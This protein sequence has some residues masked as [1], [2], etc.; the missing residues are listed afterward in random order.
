M[1]KERDLISISGPLETVF[2]GGKLEVIH[3]FTIA[4]N[5]EHPYS[6]NFFE[7]PT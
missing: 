1:K 3:Y 7:I 4:N 2:T 6:I 5:Y